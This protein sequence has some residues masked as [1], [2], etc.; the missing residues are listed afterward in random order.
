[1][2]KLKTFRTVEREREREREIEKSE[3]D[4]YIIPKIV[5]NKDKHKS[6]RGKKSKIPIRY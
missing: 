5:N 2:P 3:K 6:E 1:M 4:K